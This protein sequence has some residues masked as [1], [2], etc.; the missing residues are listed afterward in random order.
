[1]RCNAGAL[2]CVSDPGIC[3]SPSAEERRRPHREGAGWRVVSAW[4]GPAK[5]SRRRGCHPGAVTACMHG[6]VCKAAISCFL[7]PEPVSVLAVLGWLWNSRSW[8]RVPNL[9]WA[10]DL[11]PPQRF[12]RVLSQ[13]EPQSRSHRGM[14]QPDGVY[15]IPVLLGS[16]C[17]GPAAGPAAHHGVQPRVL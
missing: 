5:S 17:P 13:V 4:G 1:M 2:T 8:Q 16:L 3:S 12:L 10:G 11:P 15:P 6:A 9:S 7:L 14:W